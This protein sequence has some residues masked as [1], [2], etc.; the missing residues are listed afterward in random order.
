VPPASPPFAGVIA[1]A[2]PAVSAAAAAAIA[3]AQSIRVFMSSPLL[4]HE[5]RR[6]CKT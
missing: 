4:G 1:P 3:T 5:L 2:E 6:E